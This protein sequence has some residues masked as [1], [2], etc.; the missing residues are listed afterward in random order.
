MRV[1]HRRVNAIY[2]QNQKVEIF[3]YRVAYMQLLCALCASALK[4]G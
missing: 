4:N 3:V 1:T 2:T